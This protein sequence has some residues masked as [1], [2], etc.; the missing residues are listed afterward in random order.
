MNKIKIW[1]VY[2]LNGYSSPDLDPNKGE[3]GGALE[4]TL[5]TTLTDMDQKFM[6]NILKG[7]GAKET[8]LTL[9]DANATLLCRSETAVDVSDHNETVFISQEVVDFFE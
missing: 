6:H 5:S 9:Y 7:M 8:L 3:F 1:H 2:D 4:L